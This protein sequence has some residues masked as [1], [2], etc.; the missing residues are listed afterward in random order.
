MEL[1]SEKKETKLFTSKLEITLSVDEPKTK[2]E[3]FHDEIL[4]RRRKIAEIKQ[5]GIENPSTTINC[6]FFNLSSIIFLF[7]L[8]FSLNVGKE[9]TGHF[10]TAIFQ[11]KLHHTKF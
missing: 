7:L 4:E 1:R 3:N 2:E 6:V 11:P 9:T 10:E 5:V 8:S